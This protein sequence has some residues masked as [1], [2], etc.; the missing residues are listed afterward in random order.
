MIDKGE[1]QMLAGHNWL[2]VFSPYVNKEANK[3]SGNVFSFFLNH[4]SCF[5]SVTIQFARGNFLAIKVMPRSLWG[6]YSCLSVGVCV[7][8]TVA[9]INGTT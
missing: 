8:V 1:G 2:N 9:Q 7:C 6:G 4:L 5:T 3:R